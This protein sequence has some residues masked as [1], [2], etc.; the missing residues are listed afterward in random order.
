MSQPVEKTGKGSGDGKDKFYRLR[1]FLADSEPNSL[2]ARQN[3]DLFC[4][5]YLKDCYVLEVVDVFQDFRSALENG[6]L[7][8]PALVVIEPQVERMIFGNLSDTRKILEALGIEGAR[9]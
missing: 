6:V 3:L 8:T 5:T 2:L 7:V 1:L 9:V 4:E